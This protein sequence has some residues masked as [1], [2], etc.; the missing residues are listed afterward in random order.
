MI[1]DPE[2]ACHDHVTN[3]QQ[4]HAKHGIFCCIMSPLRYLR[5][6]HAQQ[7]GLSALLPSL[8]SGGQRNVL[9][10]LWFMLH[11]ACCAVALQICIDVVRTT[12]QSGMVRTM[13]QSGMLRHLQV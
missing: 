9:K 4:A 12:N 8:P 11:K 1:S 13:S 2:H 10:A 3:M 7:T 5:M 6:A